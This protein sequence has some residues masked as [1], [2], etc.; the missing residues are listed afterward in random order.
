VPEPA[1]RESS[2]SSR[3]ARAGRVPP[4][5]LPSSLMQEVLGLPWI[6][7]AATSLVRLAHLSDDP[8][9]FLRQDPGAVLLILRGASAIPDPFPGELLHRAEP[10]EFAL[11][12]LVTTAR[13]AVAGRPRQAS[14]LSLRKIV[15]SCRMLARLS[16]RLASR[17]GKCDPEQAW[18]AGLLA[19]L[20]WLGVCTVAP[21]V[22]AAC[23]D[24][25][26]FHRD[27]AGS[28]LRHWRITQ[29]DLARRLASN[30]HLPDW[31]AG[32]IGWLDLPCVHAQRFG[33]DPR[34]FSVV[35]LAVHLAREQGIDL[36][37]A[38]GAVE[39]EERI[40]GLSL[41]SLDAAE[42]SGETLSPPADLEDPCGRP[43]L[44]ELLAV[45]I[46]NRRLRQT[47]VVSALS[48][49]IDELHA[50][51]REQVQGEA[52]RLLA[53]K[54]SALAELAAGA[55]HEINNPLAVISGQAQY[56]LAHENDLLAADQEGVTHKALHTIINQTKRIHGIL[57]DL[58]QFA[59]PAAAR[60][61][62]VDLPTLLGEVAAG[63]AD[64][65]SQKRVRVE[66]SARPERLAASLD[67]DQV[68][69]AL[70]CVLKNAIEAAGTDGWAR[71]AL[72]AQGDGVE[73][74]IED[75]GSG[76]TAE[77]RPHLFDPFYSGRSA[78]R[79]R[80][81]GLPIA[82]RLARQQGGDLRLEPTRPG[83]PTRFVMR[84]PR[85]EAGAERQ[86]A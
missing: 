84:L 66:V 73:I 50:A 18:C 16:H 42:L 31:L 1:E 70:S 6:S 57:R 78:G 27:P 74:V 80:G 52:S 53:A 34:L 22:A 61:S 19:P 59:R 4:F 46:E 44:P 40:A 3:C 26:E 43:L 10:L 62:V 79:G 51:L 8:W 38:G 60:P 30:L 47:T 55:G 54:L 82:W 13:R 67:V 64:F 29:A 85:L 75:S 15:D 58:M 65:A 56:L 83:E 32:V 39:E 21:E 41:L 28:Q 24:D 81:L 25:P 23:L 48:R 5:P 86:A 69:T 11:Q 72:A 33:A 36:G 76:P 9:P 14:C 63:V 7:P 12:Q 2:A 17:T 77:Q 37:L 71:L 20:G 49:Q 45:A 35:R 68:R